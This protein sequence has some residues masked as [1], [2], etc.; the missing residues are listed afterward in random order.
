MKEELEKLYHKN[1]AKGMNPDDAYTESYAVIC[2][3][4]PDAEID[5]FLD[6]RGV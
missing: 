5:H 1:L 2:N 4:Y 3:R 6:G